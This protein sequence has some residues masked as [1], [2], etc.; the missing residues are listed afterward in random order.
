MLGLAT[1]PPGF[2]L[3]CCCFQ[4]WMAQRAISQF[5]HLKKNTQTSGNFRHPVVVI[6]LKWFSCPV[7]VVYMFHDLWQK[8]LQIC[9]N[10]KDAFSEKGRNKERKF[11]RSFRLSLVGGFKPF[12]KYMSN[13]IHSPGR[14]ENKRCLKPPPRKVS[15]G[16]LQDFHVLFGTPSGP[17]PLWCTSD[18]CRYDIWW[19]L[20]HLQ[21]AS[22]GIP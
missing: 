4:S 9:S 3:H 14:G 21:F 8:K 2:P 6:T 22:Q 17:L 19:S 10:K 1:S 5:A 15:L 16:R 20:H 13:W 7:V 18:V 12:E 11:Q